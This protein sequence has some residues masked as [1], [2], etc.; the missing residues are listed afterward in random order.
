MVS[1]VNKLLGVRSNVGLATVVQ[2][3]RRA[4]NQIRA[5]ANIDIM[6]LSKTMDVLSLRTRLEQEHG[7]KAPARWS[8]TQLLTRLTELEGEQVVARKS[9][10]I[11]PLRMAE[12]EVNKAAKKKAT[13]IEYVTTKWGLNL[14]GNETI[15]QLKTKAMAAA[16][17]ELPGHPKDYC[18]FGVHAAHTYEEVLKE[19]PGYCKWVVTTSKEGDSCPRLRRFSAWL[20]TEEAQSSEVKIKKD[21]YEMGK[22]SGHVKTPTSKEGYKTTASSSHVEM[23]AKTVEALSHEIQELKDVKESRRK[24]KVSEDDDTSNENGMTDA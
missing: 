5:Q 24:I 6:S 7:E 21:K 22:Y 9:A 18:G 4:T 11:S 15:D 2:A 3:I 13:L 1:V 10:I 8:R 12:I 23:L 19:D 20:Q 16:Q 17:E 14:T